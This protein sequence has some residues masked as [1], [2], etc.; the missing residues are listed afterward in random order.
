M[1]RC[2]RECQGFESLILLQILPRWCNGSHAGLRNQCSKGVWVRVSPGAPRRY[3]VIGSRSGLKIRCPLDVSV[4][5]WLP[6]PTIYGLWLSWGSWLLCKQLSVGSIPTRSTKYC[7]VA[8]RKSNR[9]I[10][11]RSTFRNCPWLPISRWCNGSIP[12]SKTV[13][14]GSSP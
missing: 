12:V 8:Q 13:G 2:Q 3:D 7:R 10:T 9:L 5:F 14:W 4:R 6:A 11:D 1:S